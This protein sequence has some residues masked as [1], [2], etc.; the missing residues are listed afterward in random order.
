MRPKIL[1]EDTSR[2][3]HLIGKHATRRRLVPGTLDLRRTTEMVCAALVTYVEE[4]RVLE[5]QCL[6]ID[7]IFPDAE[8]GQVSISELWTVA[9]VKFM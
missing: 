8:Q 3:R 1:S 2:Y 9:Y 4:F 5:S 6:V 7:E